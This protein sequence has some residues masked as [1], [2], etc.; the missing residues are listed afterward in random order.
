MCDPTAGFYCFYVHGRVFG[1]TIFLVVLLHG[2]K[3][4]KE[5]ERERERVEREGERERERENDA[6]GLQAISRLEATRPP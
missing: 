5:R 6:S 4:K 1:T 3:G 2:A